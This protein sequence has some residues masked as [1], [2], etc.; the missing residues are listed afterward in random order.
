MLEYAEYDD[1]V[2]FMNIFASMGG[3]SFTPE[4]TKKQL[5][6]KLEKQEEEKGQLDFEITDV[7][8][9]YGSQVRV[10]AQMMWGDSEA[11]ES[12]LMMRKESGRWKCD[13]WASGEE[14]ARAERESKERL[15]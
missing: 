3:K 2:S 11:E 4:T 14:D 1:L 13:L 7:Q 15:N 8:V 9:K 10:T 12:H 6:E 5:K